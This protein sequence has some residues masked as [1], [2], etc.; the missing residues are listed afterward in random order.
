[1]VTIDRIQLISPYFN[2]I[3]IIEYLFYFRPTCY[4][5]TI[6]NVFPFII[7]DACVRIK[8]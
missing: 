4:E 7:V 6:E 3:Y 5:R 2:G 1:M 8:H